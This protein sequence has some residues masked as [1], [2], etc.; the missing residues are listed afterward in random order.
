M[1]EVL[2]KIRLN[3]LAFQR[4]KIKNV[5]LVINV[6]GYAIGDSVIFFSKIRAISKFLNCLKFDVVTTRAH[7]TFLHNSPFIKLLFFDLDEA[8]LTRYDLIINFSKKDTCLAEFLCSKYQEAIM[9]GQVKFSVYSLYMQQG[10]RQT[11]LFDYFLDFETYLF[12]DYLRERDFA[13]HE[14]HISA[15][16]RDWGNRQ[17]KEY[18]IKGSE[19]VIVLLDSA[20][21]RNKLMP[22][23]EYFE[24]VRFLMSLKNTRLLV[25]DPDNSDK[26]VFYQHILNDSRLEQFIFI[27]RQG[28]RKDLCL[29][30][31]DYIQMVF[32]PCTG[33]LHCAEG[34]YNT[35][36][37]YGYLGREWPLL[38][39]YMG[40]AEL[41]DMD[42]WFWWGSTHVE[43]L[44]MIDDP[45]ARGKKKV[46]K[47]IGPGQYGLHSSQFLAAPL[48]DYF[49]DNYGE[50]FN[51]WKML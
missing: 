23:N 26:R 6:E 7:Y 27:Q 4:S 19:K 40:P 46:K 18:G 32:G 1:K 13:G 17:L 21:S 35:F 25:F 2:E 11:D 42:K 51:R 29:L 45:N 24:L 22:M 5:L 41:G 14:L 10:T 3:T 9:E 12:G 20:S 8:D 34:I 28:L 47:L 16:E 38:V 36:D 31:S 39:S 49:R 37:N 50:K 30:A 33:L 15:E 43:C 44:Y 48:I